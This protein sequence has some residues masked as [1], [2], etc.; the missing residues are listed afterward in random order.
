MRLLTVTAIIAA[1][2]SLTACESMKNMFTDKDPPLKGERLSV[3][4]LQRDLVPNPELQATP[5]VLPEA[6]NNQLWPQAGGYPTHAMGHLA[7]SGKLKKAWS[8]SIGKGASDRVPL[9]AAPVVADSTVYTLDTKGQVTAFDVATGKQKWRVSAVPKGEED[10]AAAGGGLAFESGVLYVSG[11]YRL[12][13]ALDAASGKMAWKAAIPAPGRSA[14]TIM[15]GRVYLITIDNRLLV[16]STADGAQLWKY[17][18]VSE[19]TNLLGAASVAADQTIAVLPL[20]SGDIF[21]LNPATG[22]V[23]WQDN[24]SAVRR[25]GALASIADIRGMPVLDQGLVF[26]V[27]YSGRMIASDA[28]TGQRLWQKEIGSSE[29]PWPAGDTV[30]VLSSEQQLAALSRNSGEIHWVTPL[31]RYKNDDRNKVIVWFGPVL[32]GGRLI[33]TNNMGQMA[34]V[35]PVSG[36]VLGSEKID[37]PAMLA[38]VVADNTLFVLTTNGT[39]TA[40]R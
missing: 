33:L 14:P 24:L 6:W 25:T 16:F 35:D 22:Q 26:A 5:V 37:G 11:G 4:Q 18:G 7:L 3:L 21:G 19:T 10:T 12:L 39:L 13:V 15:D 34:T 27:S 2:L 9:T 31:A 23:I 1:T 36:K 20:S 8:S 17:D 28:A 38:P 29:T 30:F 32:A 40:Y